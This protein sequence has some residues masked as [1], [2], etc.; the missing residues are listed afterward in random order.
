MGYGKW[1][2]GVMGFM[3]MGPLGALAGFAIGSLFDKSVTAQ[4]EMDGGYGSTAQE[5][6]YTGQRNSFLFSMLVMASY[7]IRADGR[8]MH[9][10]MEFVRQFLR[11]N[12]GEASV[13]EGERILLNLFEQRKRMVQ[14]DPSA[15]RRTIRECGAQIARFS[16]EDCTERRKCLLGR[17]GCLKGSGS[18]HAVVHAGSRF[19]VELER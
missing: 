18:V 17:S 8:I 12:F 4:E 7:I 2:G 16:G 6:V 3:T 14:N 11:V 5:D 9:S 15:F 1:I 19:H 13:S 10:E